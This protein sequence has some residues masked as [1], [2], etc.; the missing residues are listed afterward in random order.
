MQR[1]FIYVKDAVDVMYHSFCDPDKTGILNLG[2]GQARSWNDLAN[3][4]FSALGKKPVVEYV[5]MPEELRD[6]YQY[7]TQADMTGLKESG[8]YSGFRSLEETV[9][10]YV[11]YLKGGTYL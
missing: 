6:K 2:T 3:A 5:D 11:E 7:F 10:D 8:L 9:K 1:D 4:I